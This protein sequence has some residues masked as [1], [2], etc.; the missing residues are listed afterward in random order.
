MSICATVGVVVGTIAGIAVTALTKPQAPE[1][2]ILMTTL[3]THARWSSVV[4]TH[5]PDGVSQPVSAVTHEKDPDNGWIYGH[6]HLLGGKGSKLENNLKQMLVECRQAGAFAYKVEDMP[7]YCGEEGD[8]E[9]ILDT[10]E[11][12]FR[13]HR[14]RSPQEQSIADEKCGEKAAAGMIARAPVNSYK[15]AAS[16]VMPDKKDADG[17]LTEKRFCVDFRDLNAV[18]E[19]DKYSMPLPEDLFNRVKNAKIFTKIDLR[20]G[21]HQI[22]V[23]K[24]D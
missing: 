15:Y 4:N 24:E 21:F 9:I 20:A 18:T 2:T 12:V 8:A 19:A 6:R 5:M 3:A 16:P 22:P 13:D 14:R 11:K 10:E 23:R 7:G 1:H 17:N